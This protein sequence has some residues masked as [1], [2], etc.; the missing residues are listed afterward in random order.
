LRSDGRWRLTPVILATW[1]ALRSG[2]L[3]PVWTY[4]SRDPIS[5]ITGAKLTGGV[6]QAVQLLLCK[7]KAL[8]S[9]TNPTKNKKKRRKE[10]KKKRIYT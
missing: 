8:S 7:C 6:A 5:K 9:N 3:R 2:D 1:G 4:S 10:K